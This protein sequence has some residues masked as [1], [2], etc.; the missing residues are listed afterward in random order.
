MVRYIEY[1]R[2][3]IFEERREREISGVASRHS[4]RSLLRMGEGGGV[5]TVEIH[6]FI[7]LLHRAK[8]NRS[9]NS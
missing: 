2:I 3:K 1:E 7:S 8:E 4:N 5:G 6:F 9:T